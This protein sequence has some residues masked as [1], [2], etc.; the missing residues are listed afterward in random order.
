MFVQGTEAH[1][2]RSEKPSAWDDAEEVLLGQT[3]VYLH[4]TRMLL[5]FA[6]V[7]MSR[8]IRRARTL[9]AY[10]VLCFQSR[11]KVQ[12]P[13]RALMPHTLIVSNT[14]NL[15]L[16]VILTIISLVSDHLIS[17][18][19]ALWLRRTPFR[20]YLGLAQS[21]CHSIPMGLQSNCI[22]YIVGL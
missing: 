6:A 20:P 5:S 12:E 4:S 22:S 10:I 9:R 8:P 1:I 18:L 16:I 19:W 15:I 17:L 21:V 2:R 11:F 14:D 7:L 13:F 3:S